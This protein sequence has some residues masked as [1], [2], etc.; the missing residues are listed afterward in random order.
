MQHSTSNPDDVWETTDVTLERASGG[1]GL[2][3]A[4]SESGGDIS[5]TRIAPNGAAKSDG[6]LQTG[7]I[8]LQVTTHIHILF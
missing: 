6:R 7:D 5:I 4:G 1:L 8:L 2:S 3:I